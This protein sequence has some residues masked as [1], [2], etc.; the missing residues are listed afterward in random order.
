MA[1]ERIIEIADTYLKKGAELGN[2]ISL[3]R[4]HPFTR[5]FKPHATSDEVKIAM[6][7][8][9]QAKLIKQ[10][11]APGDYLLEPTGMDVAG[12]LRAHLDKLEQRSNVEHA[13]QLA[14]VESVKVMKEQL[15]QSKQAA[16]QANTAMWWSI[17]AAI[18]SA[19]A[20]LI[21]IIISLG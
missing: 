3:S 9:M 14:T 21:A 8:L 2:R 17:G 20:A 6:N 18:V 11:G 7:L 15:E 16:D 1:T 12:N 5:T 10:M 13:A 4:F 19:A